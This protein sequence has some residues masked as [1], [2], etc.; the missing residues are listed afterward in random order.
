M[1]DLFARNLALAR[2][3]LPAHE[4]SSCSGFYGV[5]FQSSASLL[6][7][8]ERISD[9]ALDVLQAQFTDESFTVYGKYFLSCGG[10]VSLR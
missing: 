3:E 4:K 9:T 1:I 6:S 5:P 8:N 7:L 2:S 10:S